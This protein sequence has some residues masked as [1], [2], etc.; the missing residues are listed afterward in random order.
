[1]VLKEDE[2][3]VVYSPVLD[4][5]TSGQTFEEAQKRFVEAATLFFE[6][7]TNKNTTDEVLTE[8][9]WHKIKNDWQPPVVIAQE[10]RE[11]A[12]AL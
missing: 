12:V 9:G 3:F 10:S 6:E 8:L 2:R 1:M 5:S 11:V 7:I 4:L